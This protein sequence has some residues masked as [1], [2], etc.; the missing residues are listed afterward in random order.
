M[1]GLHHVIT[2]DTQ[3]HKLAGIELLFFIDGFFVSSL[4]SKKHYLSESKV[5][6]M[7]VLYLIQIEV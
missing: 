2:A 5:I 7:K 3:T 4:T 6:L 1:K